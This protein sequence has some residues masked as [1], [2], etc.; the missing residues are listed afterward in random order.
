MRKW[1]L[2]N[3][4]NAFR[5]SY[6]W[7]MIASAINAAEAV[8][9]LMVAS[10]TVGVEMTGVLTISFT[11][12]NLMMCIGKYGVRNFQVTDAKN[13][14]TFTE[15]Y[16][17]RWVTLCFMVLA[18][19]LYVGYAYVANGYT[20]E[21]IVIVLSVVFIYAIE[22]YE[23]VF[24]SGLQHINR[25]DIGTK[26]FSLRWMITLMT[27]CVGL[28]VLRNAFYSTLFAAVINFII[29]IVLTRIVRGTIEEKELRKDKRNSKRILVMCLPLC[30]SMFTAIYL[31]NAAKYA[32]DACLS[33]ADQAYYGFVSMPVFV[34]D[35]VSMVIFQPLLVNLSDEWNE[36]KYDVF[37]RRIIRLCGVVLGVSLVVLA[38]GY[39]LGIP[40]LSILYGVD[41]KPFK[42]ELMILL[43]GGSA[44]GF[45]GLFTSVLT[46]IRKQKYLMISYVITSVVAL[47][48]LNG[49]VSR[50]GMIGAATANTVL[51]LLLVLELF[52]GMC[53]F[54]RNE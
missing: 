51:L 16:S 36:S 12:A 46:I 9:V 37:N 11:V 19:F 30:V 23:D 47:L 29:V 33:D 18:S 28:V 49:I 1:L 2:G 43:L 48:S 52:L 26:M 5:E 3:P 42:F 8:L 38:G 39:L 24:L 40:I 35:I 44:L 31:P 13:E 6:I 10:R 50:Y 4:E 25:L 27:W 41:L 22:A 7:N 53:V 17:T 14:F 34:I 45:I 15:Y 54:I 21:K 20:I 32:I